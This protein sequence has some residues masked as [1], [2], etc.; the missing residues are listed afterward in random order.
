MG[1]IRYTTVNPKVTRGGMGSSDTQHLR[2]QF[3][4]SPIGKSILIDNGEINSPL[5]SAFQQLCMVGTVPENL[6]NNN[7]P[8]ETYGPNGFSRDYPAHPDF[9][10]YSDVSTGP[11]GLPAGPFA[12]NPSSSPTCSPSDLPTPPDG[13]G[14]GQRPTQYGSGINATSRSPR[15]SSALISLNVLGTYIKGS[16]VPG[17]PE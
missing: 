13:F 9:P 12:P 5:R 15:I 2:R 10:D 4:N 14:K 8:S 16:S 1:D 7:P 17:L 6:S 11:G 3:P